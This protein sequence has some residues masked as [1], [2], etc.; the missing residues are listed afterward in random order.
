MCGRATL[1]MVESSV[2]INV[3]SIRAPV[4]GKRLSMS[5]C[6][7]MRRTRLAPSGGIHFRRRACAEGAASSRLALAP[8]PWSSTGFGS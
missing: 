5:T 4:I 6:D 1:A 3:A 8:Q 7:A 2:F